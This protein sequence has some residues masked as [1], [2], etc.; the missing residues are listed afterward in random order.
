M[1][2]AAS[3]QLHLIG[4]KVLSFAVEIIRVSIDDLDIF[5]VLLIADNFSHTG[6]Q[7]GFNEFG[8]VLVSSSLINRTEQ[9]F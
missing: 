5:R 2:A 7:T 9:I 3:S 4:Q 1:E 8:P 6:P